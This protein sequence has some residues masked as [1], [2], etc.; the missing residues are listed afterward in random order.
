MTP[1]AAAAKPPA[2]TVQAFWLMV[3]KTVAFCLSVVLP[4]LLVRIFSQRDYGIFKQAFVIVGTIYAIMSMGVGISAFYFLPRK[5]E[6]RSQIALNIV[7]FNTLAGVVPFVV[8]A[9]YPHV[10][11]RIFGGNELVGY[12][13]LIG[14]VMLFTIF[15]S[16]IELIATALQDVKWS[17]AL[18]ISAQ[19]SK[20]L[21]MTTAALW[22]RS[23]EALLYAA[24]VQGVLQSIVLLWYLHR[25]F[26][27]FWASFD[28]RFFREQIGYALP[29]GLNG[30][31]FTVQNDLHN[32]FVAHAFG[33]ATFAV[34]AVGCIQI[35]LLGVMRD[36]L[37]AVL[38]SRISALQHQ[39]RPREILLLTARAVGKVALVYLP[40]YA[41]LLVVGRDLLVFLYTR[42]YEASWPVFAINLT[43]LPLLILIT[44]PIIRS[45]AQVRFFL[46]RVRV[47][48][49]CVEI[50]L[51]WMAIHRFGIQGAIG[52]LVLVTVAERVIVSWKTASM[53]GMRAADLRL[54][55]GVL[56]T[57]VASAGA[58]AVAYALR[59][60]LPAA[61]PFA[62]LVSC[63]TA[64]AVVFGLLA[65]RLKVLTAED[66]QLLRRQWK[67]LRQ[68]LAPVRRRAP[69]ALSGGER[70]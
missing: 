29:Y 8:M 1:P 42:N 27:R 10:L 21:L 30:L 33:P 17:T 57:A 35:P 55:A 62:V 28:W 16:F 14:A 41:L 59:R 5:N 56:R 12:A 24:L 63:G 51:L 68:R 3:A 61:P 20:V 19:L 67:L 46:V 50:A 2:L 31:L 40:A 69:G 47:V 52:A 34:Y 43:M 66:E 23:V 45:Y 11:V 15:S 64:F 36:S 18:I 49:L 25:R 9:L 26:G 39:D 32:Y 70:I 54:F 4:L 6:G 7:L 65:L 58:A 53:I 37:T 38:I 22:W 13:R 48:L 44:D 60:A